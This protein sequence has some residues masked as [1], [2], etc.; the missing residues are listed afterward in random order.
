MAS[1]TRRRKV[2]KRLRRERR[3]YNQR[4]AKGNREERQAR[5]S[6]SEAATLIKGMT[7][8]QAVQW[9]RTKHFPRFGN[10]A[11]M[12]TL[13]RCASMEREKAT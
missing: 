9:S 3:E 4:R 10:K 1:H 8:W 12:E 7:G 6:H 2:L 11:E 5:R 13:R